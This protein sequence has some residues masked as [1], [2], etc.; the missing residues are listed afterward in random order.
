[1]QYILHT[2]PNLN[3]VAVIYNHTTKLWYLCSF[4]SQYNYREMCCNLIKSP[5]RMTIILIYTLY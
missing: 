1:M 3:C 2:W 5:R 4:H